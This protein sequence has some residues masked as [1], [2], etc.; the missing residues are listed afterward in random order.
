VVRVS[1][2][3]ASDSDR[4]QAAERLRHATAEGRLTAHELEQRL[5]ALYRTRTYGELDSLVADLP[6]GSSARGARVGVPR[7]VGATGA[8]ALLLAVVGLLGVARHR[9][10]EAVVGPTH[11][12][13]FGVAAAPL[14]SHRLMITAA[15]GVAVFALVVG[16]IVVLW[17]LMRSRDASGG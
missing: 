5:E 16:C 7:W 17:L 13:Q 8:L 14:G 1:S 9:S 11:A 3:R 4:E 6:V 2:L 10:T 12:G 15:F